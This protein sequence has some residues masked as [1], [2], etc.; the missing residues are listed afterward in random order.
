MIFDYHTLI[1]SSGTSNI[2]FKDLLSQLRQRNYHLIHQLDRAKGNRAF[3]QHFNYLK[4]INTKNP[5]LFNRKLVKATHHIEFFGTVDIDKMLGRSKTVKRE[6]INATPD[7]AKSSGII[8]A[9]AGVFS[10]ESVIRKENKSN[11]FWRNE[12]EYLNL[13]LEDIANY[14]KS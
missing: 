11:N 6:N 8:K 10:P 2:L 3:E 4:K 14:C 12:L 1:A 7:K 13:D 9:E 5:D